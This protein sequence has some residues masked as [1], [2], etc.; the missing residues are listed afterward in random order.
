MA[1]HDTQVHNQS[2][3][4]NATTPSSRWT[5]PEALAEFGASVAEHGLAAYPELV[6]DLAAAARPLRPV[7][8]DVLASNREPM[9]AR[10]RALAVVL[11]ALSRRLT[12]P[13]SVVETNQSVRDER[14]LTPSL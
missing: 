1:P 2:D 14:C 13:L 8:A 6:A 9:A 10:E 12:E 5:S 4:H 3:E 7:A 11:T